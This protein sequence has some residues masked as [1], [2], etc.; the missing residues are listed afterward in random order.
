MQ[1]KPKNI[2]IE[3][4]QFIEETKKISREQFEV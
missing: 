4:E 2:S 3:T 1:E